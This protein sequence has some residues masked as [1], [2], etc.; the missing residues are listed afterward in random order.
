MRSSLIEARPANSARVYPTQAAPHSK[1]PLLPRAAKPPR[2]RKL[3]H[4]VPTEGWLPLLLLSIAVY[5]VVYS[6]T[7]AIAINHTGVLWITTAMGLACGLIV[8]KSRY[9]PQAVLHIA[10]CI[11][12]YWLAL[13]LTSSLAYHVS[14][15]EI[16][17]SL[18]GVVANGF[19]L[20]GTPASD[21][22][23]LFYLAFLCFFLG[24]FGS[25]LIYRAH[26]PW[27][28]ALVYVSIM[29]V[30]LNYIAKRDLTFLVLILVGAL[31]PLIARVQ[32][33]GQLTQWKNEGLYTDQ[34]WLRNLTNRFLRIVILFALLILPL[35]WLLPVIHQP[36]S[37][38][39]L[40]NNLDNAWANL[41]HGNLASLSDPN[42]LFSPYQPSSNFFGDQLTITGNVS[43][44]DGPVLSYTSATNTKGQYLEGFSFD[45]FDGHSWTSLIQNPEGYAGNS[46]LPSSY[47]GS[48]GLKPLNTFI[49]ILQPPDGT[50]HFIFAPADP[51][52]FTVPV[53]IFTDSTGNFISAWTQTT[54]L[55]KN[56]HYQ[57]TSMLSTLSPIDLSSIALPSI[58]PQPWTTNL[59]YN[60]LKQYYL[61]VPQLSP[62]VLATA[63]TWTKG[64]TTVYD[65]V[66]ALQA[67]LS[68]EVNF[69][70]S[71]SNPPVPSNIDAV[72]WLLHTHQGYCT[73]YATAMVMMA[74][75]LGIPARIVNGFSQGH[76][77]TQQ[78][79][80]LV[81]G[82]DAHSWVQ[83]YF[84]NFGWMNFDPTPGFSINNAGIFTPQPTVKP[85]KTPV[86]PRSTATPIAHTTPAV[87]PTAT[88][89]HPGTST[90][91]S[92]S[93][94]TVAGTNLF[95]TLSLLVL[96]VSCL[97]LGLAVLRYRHTTRSPQT[98]STS[99]YTRLC[100]IAALVGLPPSVWQTPYEY[101]FALSKRFPQVS[102]SL[103]L[104]AELFVRERW[105]SPQHAPAPGEQQE[106]ERLWPGLRNTILR[107]PFS[108]GK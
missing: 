41:S 44:P 37:G 77:D 28:V 16:L 73:Y 76:Y 80:W 64:D 96:I 46:Q 55:L 83:V 59:S 99:M 94:D 21:M 58:D 62:E 29:I 13:I 75:E 79:V 27:L 43:L 108:K 98:I 14:L 102:T 33:A 65:V 92:S 106:L 86:T 71:V 82:G 3:A 8:S 48:I 34:V 6:V 78:Q 91:R 7:A 24:Y 10:A 54:P 63:Q 11:L 17:A 26:L 51:G 89:G 25:W 107:S 39:M 42:K 56:E 15:L 57:V 32:L 18:H 50:K 100:R 85:G 84:P 1:H 104:L 81:N 93:S 22:V 88:A 9:F 45:A 52:K 87:H 67:H 4:L 60:E 36:A 72:T 30:N 49:T 103:R 53:T 97:V 38:V 61:Q 70:Y 101:T 105:A 20:A 47:S 35:S 90:G 12:G 74:R 2:K 40:W 19:S 31:L 95:M 66:S 69:K 23:F 68:N 5:S